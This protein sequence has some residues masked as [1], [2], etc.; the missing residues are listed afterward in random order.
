[1]KI[2]K[3]ILI[4]AF[5]LVA[6]PSYSSEYVVEAR[7]T[8]DSGKAMSFAPR[9]LKV[10]VG[11]TVTFKPSDACHNAESFFS[12][13]EEASFKTTHGEV[14]SI[15]MSQEGVYLY[16]C[17]PHLT[18]DMVGI[19]QVSSSGKEQEASTAQKGVKEMISM[20]ERRRDYSNK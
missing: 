14:T 3:G 8:G 11:D 6:V 10:E 17:T 9:Y 12:P 16:K 20:M 2:V 18:G 15:K 5:T 19:I 1:M 7:K 13:T 4:F